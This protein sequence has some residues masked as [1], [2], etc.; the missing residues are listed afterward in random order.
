M[1]LNGV[2]QYCEQILTTSKCALLPFHNLEHTKEVVD[3]VKTIG[4]HEGFSKEEIETLQIAAWF[5]DT[6]FSETYSGHEEASIKIAKAFLSQNGLLKGRIN[7][8]LSAIEATKMPQTAK[9]RLDAVLCDAD[10]YHIGT[11][12]F[13]FKKLLLR[14]EWSLFNIMDIEDVEWYKLNRDFLH[15]HHFK[16]KYGKEVLEKVKTANE[17]KVKYILSFCE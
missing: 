12:D 15:N 5:H 17:K 2:S 8:I 3:N 7:K 10:V 9:N 4:E 6:G 1:I 14:L 13:F 11:C 16:T